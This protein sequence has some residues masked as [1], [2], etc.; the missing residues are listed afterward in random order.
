MKLWQ[1]ISIVVFLFTFGITE[2]ILSFITPKFEKEIIS[3]H[4]EKLKAIAATAAAYIEG[5]EYKSLDFSDPLVTETEL[6]KKFR[7]DLETV[8]RNLNLKEELYTVALLEGNKAIFGV[9]T[10]SIPFSGDTLHISA[11]E[12]ILA[13]DRVGSTSD[14][15]YTDIYM[16]QYGTWV[17]GMAPI[18]DSDNKV[19]GIV[20][21]DHEAERVYAKIDEIKMF[22]MLIQL[23]SIPFLLL[24]SILLSKITTKP[25]SKVIERIDKIAKGDYSEQVKLSAGKEVKQLA[26]ATETLRKT[27]LEQ[28]QKIFSSIEELKLN[29]MALHEAKEQA[30]A[31]DRLK[32]EFLAMISHE[33]RTPLNV[34]LNYLELIEMELHQDENAEAKMFFD[35]VR[36]AS[37]RLIR[38]IEL[39]ITTAQLHSGSIDFI[40]EKVDIKEILLN[41][42][43][44]MEVILSSKKVELI[45]NIPNETAEIKGDEFLLYKMFENLLE[46]ASIFTNEGYVS[47]HL[48]KDDSG[49][50]IFSV[51]DTGLGIS[52][53]FQERM[54]EIFEQEDAGYTRKFDGNGLGLSLVK[55]V[56]EIHRAEL[57]W[58]SEKGKG[59][60]FTIKFPFVKENRSSNANMIY[61]YT[62]REFTL[63]T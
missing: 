45:Y 28:Q 51:E 57:S 33:V 53:K 34:I 58:K 24:V 17:S 46:N 15:S 38:T 56:C 19:V 52:E 31:S 20:Q 7:K 10:N 3:L 18:I 9:M 12:A 6:F 39:I 32:S 37:E 35:T 5:D 61:S 11:E 16:D 8:K 54:F 21:A 44:E 59:T 47:I 62:H 50:M 23:G 27:V 22:I 14:C 48:E 1:K 2:I 4:G 49:G 30:E 13:Y 43:A 40:E 63:D 42:K 36:K 60:I 29:N 41:L 26:E 25:I 55:K